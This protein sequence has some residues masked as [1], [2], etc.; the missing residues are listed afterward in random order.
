[1]FITKSPNILLAEL[2]SINAYQGVAEI[3]FQ[4]KFNT[5]RF[6]MLGLKI[7]VLNASKTDIARGMSIWSLLGKHAAIDDLSGRWSYS[8]R[9]SARALFSIALNSN[10][11]DG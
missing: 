4:F 10:M 2:T 6:T 11:L 5:P 8:N 1:M 9:S 7:R 3:C